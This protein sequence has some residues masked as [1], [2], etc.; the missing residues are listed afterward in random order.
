MVDVLKYVH[1]L[2]EEI[3][4]RPANTEEEYYASSEIEKLM[5]EHGVETIVQ[6]FQVPTFAN[7]S[8]AICFVGMFLTAALSGIN[9]ILSIITF[10]FSLIFLGLF[11]AERF[12]KGLLSKLGTSGVSQNV[13]ARHPGQK[14]DSERRVRPIVVLANYDSPKADLLS[15]PT[16]SGFKP[17]LV[18]LVNILMLVVPVINLL[19]A[20]AVLPLGFRN[21]LWA[22]SIVAALPILL[23]GVNLLISHFAL[24]Y[25]HGANDNA[26]GVAAMMGIL[27]HTDPLGLKAPKNLASNQVVLEDGT[28]VSFEQIQEV[29]EQMSLEQK[30]KE[31]DFEKISKDLSKSSA[32]QQ[33][34]I[35]K[36]KS[37]RR[38]AGVARAAGVL[39]E[40]VEIV[41][42]NE[43]ALLEKGKKA[44]AL[45]EQTQELSLPLQADEQAQENAAQAHEAELEEKT[46]EPKDTEEALSARDR[47]L[48]AMAEKEALEAERRKK[49]E[50][51]NA[52]EAALA[53]QKP[54]RPKPPKDED[55]NVQV[56]SRFADLPIKKS[57]D[58]DPQVSKVSYEPD[59]PTNTDTLDTAYNNQSQNVEQ[60]DES[61]SVP[62][63]RP[64]K[65]VLTLVGEEPAKVEE[66]KIQSA[67]DVEAAPSFDFN[68]EDNAKIPNYDP[69]KAVQDALDAGKLNDEPH[70][71]EP[72]PSRVRQI[73]TLGIEDTREQVEQSSAQKM[74][75]DDPT[76]GR[77]NFNPSKHINI[78]DVPDPSL[79]EQDPYESSNITYMDDINFNPEDFPADE[80][81]KGAYESQR[82]SRSS[83]RSEP[84]INM[85]KD[86]VFQRFSNQVGK[87]FKGKN[88]EEDETFSDWLG[89]DEDF[90]AKKDGRKIGSWDNFDDDQDNWRG[91]GTKGY[92]DEERENLQKNSLDQD[93]DLAQTPDKD[94][95]GPADQQ[96][97]ATEQVRELSDNDQKQIRD[98]VM[99]M[100]DSDLA[101]HEIWYVATGASDLRN[102]GA[103]AFFEEY[104][105][106]LR[107]ALVINLKAVGAGQLSV[108]SKEGASQSRNGDRRLINI[109][110]KVGKEFNRPVT[111]VDMSWMSTDATVAMQ[112]GHRSV[113]I[114]GT[115]H[116]VITA[117]A[118]AGDIVDIVDE[119]Q[120]RDVIDI[121]VETIR[122]S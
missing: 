116:G 3:G 92:S 36:D 73:D 8:Y 106:E 118:W 17:M 119:D 108:L 89:V 74:L 109:V 45:V 71:F 4:V 102:A 86:N 99:S 100:S 78:L 9:S 31:K 26:S 57:F 111:A 83:R 95:Q 46:A 23:L 107:G 32:E 112:S 101:S 60:R 12:E 79:K 49:L 72:A 68:L 98:Y 52:A 96:L 67:E 54:D 24:G 53:R 121:V 43:D 91:G 75:E 42:T 48:Q 21:F 80:F 19:H 82:N 34:L 103:R 50:E 90:D 61:R 62:Q 15:N 35:S 64:E 37:I 47:Y 114:A 7:L 10:V 39:P 30:K 20:I 40:G 59:A 25:V 115:D 1:Y 69:E 104:S 85:P 27:D 33:V 5:R 63:N 110:K 120:I 22:L 44:L 88:K 105:S 55:G 94:G 6:E 14:T 16:F 77:T 113:T 41:Y 117:S 38:G 66:K 122:R 13:I 65:P 18:K 28:S 51:K 2:S 81:E 93:D 84:Q 97:A 70:K 11:I 87:L 56:R 29:A 76:W 58:E